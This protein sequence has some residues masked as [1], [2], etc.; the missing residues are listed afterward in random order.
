ME[1]RDFLEESEKASLILALALIREKAIINRIQLPKAN[2]TAIY[3]I[4]DGDFECS[5]SPSTTIS[6]SDIFRRYVTSVYKDTF[7]REPTLKNDTVLL[8]AIEKIVN[9]F[10]EIYQGDDFY[11]IKEYK[12]QNI[13]RK[14]DNFFE[15]Y[16]NANISNDDRKIIATSTLVANH[17]KDMS[18]ELDIDSIIDSLEEG[19]TTEEYINYNLTDI[20]GY[21]DWLH[22]PKQQYIDI[23]SEKRY[24]KLLVY[25][26]ASNRL[27]PVISN[28]INL[29]NTLSMSYFVNKEDENPV[30]YFLHNRQCMNSDSQEY[31][32]SLY[33][34]LLDKYKIPEKMRPKTEKETEMLILQLIGRTKTYDG[35]HY[36]INRYIDSGIVSDNYGMDNRIIG[37]TLLTLAEI[38]KTDKVGLPINIIERVI[39]KNYMMTLNLPEA[40]LI[41]I[42]SYGK[43]LNDI[44]NDK[45]NNPDNYN[46]DYDDQDYDDQDYDDYDNDNNLGS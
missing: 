13:S 19:I 33:G 30:I 40:P 8:S 10:R 14:I 5:F 28:F 17:F 16:D 22:T 34:D 44:Y 43:A 12:M 2:N 18:R 9:N 27:T 42:K 37:T 15:H 25:A 4:K 29:D 45:L 23:E 36:L 46:E 39:D 38:L 7:N 1:D 26:Y 32:V 3:N 24:I 41:F 21:T 20:L 6:F 11:S 31:L 35:L